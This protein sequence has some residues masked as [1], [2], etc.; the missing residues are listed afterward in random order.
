MSKKTVKI[1]VRLVT[2]IEI[3]F[4]HQRQIYSGSVIKMIAV[5]KHNDEFFHHGIA[6]VSYTWTVSETRVLDL[7]LPTKQELAQVH[8]IGSNLAQTSR[9]VRDNEANREIN[10][11]TAFNS[12]SIYASGN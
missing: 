7:D 12:S 6:P 5:L 3:P 1:R 8:G 10:F 11:F 9:Y 2:S 4:S